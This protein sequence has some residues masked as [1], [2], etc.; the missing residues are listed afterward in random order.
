MRFYSAYHSRSSSCTYY[1]GSEFFNGYL[2]RFW[3]DCVPGLTW[4]RSRPYHKNDNRFVEQRNGDLV[5]GYL[6]DD[7][8]DTVMQTQTLNGLFDLIW[9]HFNFFQRVRRLASRE[10]VQ[11]DGCSRVGRHFDTAAAPY[12]RLRVSGVLSAATTD[13]LDQLY[14]ETNPRQLRR[15]I[16]TQ[17]NQLFALPGAPPGI[18][19]DIFETV[20]LTIPRKEAALSVTSADE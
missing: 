9:L 12:E 8:L 13:M 14:R 2:I 1:Y 18:T 19:E 16:Y 5:R 7:R 3:E 20:T 10:F 17:I 4:S 15:R 6:G 11:T